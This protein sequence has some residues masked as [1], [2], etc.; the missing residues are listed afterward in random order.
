MG[1]EAVK[2]KRRVLRKTKMEEHEKLKQGQDDL[3]E[4]EEEDEEAE[5]D[6]EEETDYVDLDFVS[7]PGSIDRDFVSKDV[8]PRPVNTKHAK[9]DGVPSPPATHQRSPK[10]SPP[11]LSKF[12]RNHIRANS[13]AE[14]IFGDLVDDESGHS[15]RRHMV[16]MENGMLFRQSV[17]VS[18]AL[19]VCF[20]SILCLENST[21]E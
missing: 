9:K 6:A 13:K 10:S 18:L 7:K 15:G 17:S 3:Q 12:L 11:S 14:N 2:K 16:S 5:S 19:T 1:K 20:H 8:T 4:G 21:T